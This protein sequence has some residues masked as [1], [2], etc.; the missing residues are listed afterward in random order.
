MAIVLSRRQKSYWKVAANPRHLC[1][2]N[3]SE[4]CALLLFPLPGDLFL[5][6]YDLDRTLRASPIAHI[7]TGKLDARASAEPTE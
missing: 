1:S 3:N 6:G 7:I 5:K 4:D 2:W